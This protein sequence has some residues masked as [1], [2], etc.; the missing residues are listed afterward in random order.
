M[1]NKLQPINSNVFLTVIEKNT[2]NNLPENLRE[3]VTAKFKLQLCKHSDYE[4]ESKIAALVTIT[5]T[6]SGVRDAAD[7]KVT[8]FLRE[9]LFRDLRRPQFN[10]LTFAEIE[11]AFNKGVRQEYGQYM[12]VNIQT[13]HNWLRSYINSKGR[14]LAFKQFYNDVNVLE[15]GSSDKNS[16]PNPE[17]IKKVL[18]IL[19]P[20]S[21]SSKPKYNPPAKKVIEKSKRDI[22]IQYCLTRFDKVFSKNPIDTPG[23]FIK[24]KGEIV[25]VTEY[26][27]IK[28]NRYF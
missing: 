9:T 26:L 8:T 1:E 23:K 7:P 24:Y 6:E 12:G 19:K 13:M 15:H 4:L 11:L 28:L 10:R 3:F 16:K 20:L 21:D 22:Y 18:E 17:G 14:E 2:I 27:T 25:D 5:L